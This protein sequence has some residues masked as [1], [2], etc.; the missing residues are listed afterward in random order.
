[1]TSLYVTQADVND[2]HFHLC[3]VLAIE[4]NKAILLNY[5]TW[6]PN[7]FQAKFS[8]MYQCKRTF[9]YTTERPKRNATKQQVVDQVPLEE[10][11]DFIDHYDVRVTKRMIISRKS[12]RQLRKLG[13][14]HHILGK[15]FPY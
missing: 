13:L 8:P 14:K 9:R 11:D 7:I 10:A 3:R 12:I 5:A 6:T 2:C 1:M 4:D 15:T